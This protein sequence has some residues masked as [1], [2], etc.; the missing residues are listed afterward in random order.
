MVIIEGQYEVTPC[1]DPRGTTDQIRRVRFRKLQCA[2][3]SVIRISGLTKP[4]F[5]KGEK[6]DQ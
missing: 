1:E 6:H 2:A 3:P 4:T 5:S